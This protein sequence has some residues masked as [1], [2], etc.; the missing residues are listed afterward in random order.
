M[1]AE[2]LGRNPTL[3][4]Y[5][6]AMLGAVRVAALHDPTDTRW[7]RVGADLDDA[8]QQVTQAVGGSVEQTLIV[9]AV[10]YGHHGYRTHRL[11][12]ELICA[13]QAVTAAHPVSPA[14]VGNWIDAEDGLAGQVCPRVEPGPGWRAR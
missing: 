4:A 3:G 9:T 11:S 1:R 8:G 14:T 7:V 2:V 12:L 13:M 10:G 5:Y 6:Q